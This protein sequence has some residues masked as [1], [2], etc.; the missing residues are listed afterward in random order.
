MKKKS[1]NKVVQTSEKDTRNKFEWWKY[2]HR[3]K[4]IGNFITKIL[5]CFSRLDRGRIKANG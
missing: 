4:C 3:N 5:S 2:N 1:E